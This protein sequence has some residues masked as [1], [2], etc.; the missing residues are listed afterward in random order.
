MQ[1]SSLQGMLIVV[2]SGGLVSL[3]GSE[4]I[5]GCVVEIIRRIFPTNKTIYFAFV[6]P[7]EDSENFFMRNESACP[8]QVNSIYFQPA[9]TLFTNGPSQRLN[10]TRDETCPTKKVKPKDLFY[11]PASEPYEEQTEYQTQRTVCKVVRGDEF[12]E[13]NAILKEIHSQN[14]WKVITAVFN[15]RILGLRLN[16]ENGYLILLRYTSDFESFMESLKIKQ[17]ELEEMAYMNSIFIIIILGKPTDMKIINSLF[18]FL[19]KEIR[20]FDAIVMTRL[21]PEEIE[22][23]TSVRDNC[24]RFK[25]VISLN[26]WLNGSFVKDFHYSKQ[27][28]ES[29][30]NGCELL[31]RANE[32]PP[33]V[34][35]NENT[36]ELDGLEVRILEYITKHLGMFPI[37]NLV[38]ENERQ[39]IWIG[40]N[41]LYNP[42]ELFYIERYYVVQYEWVVPL[43]ESYPRWSSITRVFSVTV[44]VATIICSIL[45][46][47][48]MYCIQN[49]HQ[50]LSEARGG[51]LQYLDIWA[52][53]LGVSVEI[54]QW[55][56][57]R[58]VFLAWVIFS[59]AFSMIFQAFMTSYF[60]DAG[61]QHQ[62]DTYDELIH[63]N[64]TFA[65]DSILM[66]VRHTCFTGRDG[67]VTT[68]GTLFLMLFWSQNSN[69]AIMTGKDSFDY[70][71]PKICT[72]VKFLRI[73]GYS[74]ESDMKL[75]IRQNSPYLPRINQLTIRM[76]EGGIPAKIMKTIT[77]PKD[78]MTQSQSTEILS[79]YSAL[80]LQHVVCSF[81]FLGIGYLLS[82]ISF[83]VELII[84]RSIHLSMSLG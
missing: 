1:F 39:E 5:T 12:S 60:T 55:N 50:K 81:L 57:L 68:Q 42:R 47:I 45:I 11:F 56:P 66:T 74:V 29:S 79:D 32:N 21:I 23:F 36:Q 3:E 83:I 63:S 31:I 46:T 30:F 43:A 15:S 20:S 41:T 54:P 70:T 78:I 80:S 6:D 2:I 13:E 40:S 27:K 38:N 26:K 8:L 14:E 67:Y 19:H 22:I 16:N 9:F 62:I 59:F 48:I 51:R 72:A 73:I 28:F 44:W 64:I 24:G 35:V 49:G 4:P 76:V 71:M 65:F 61:K 69:V 7:D 75:I 37:F 77:N 82:L 84:P 53:F 58:I 25:E 34:I 10:A 52:I 17:L 33:F 18:F